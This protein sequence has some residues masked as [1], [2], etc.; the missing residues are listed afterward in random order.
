MEGSWGGGGGGGGAGV[1]GR[2]PGLP[3]YIFR[4]SVIPQREQSCIELDTPAL[5]TKLSIM[6]LFTDRK[7]SSHV[8]KQHTT[9]LVSLVSIFE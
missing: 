4:L 5:Y 6:F 2:S 1:D 8:G 9:L 3:D 7:V